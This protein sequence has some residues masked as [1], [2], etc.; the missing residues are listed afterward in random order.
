MSR[1]I[2]KKTPEILIIAGFDNPLQTFFSQVF[3]L[4]QETDEEDHIVFWNGIK[5]KEITDVQKL[6]EALKPYIEAIP[7]DIKTQLQLDYDN[8][9]P[10][11]VLQMFAARF[12][13][14]HE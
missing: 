10:P 2:L 9:T 1:Y 14:N 6:E 7:E 4:V 8:R 12:L 5:P 13:E 3:D 11:S